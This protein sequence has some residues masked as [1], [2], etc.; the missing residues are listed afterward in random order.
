[1]GRIKDTTKERTFNLDYD[2][3]WKT[4]EKKTVLEY[5]K[6]KVNNDTE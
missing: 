6:H 1:M 4:E 2:R 3:A 5:K